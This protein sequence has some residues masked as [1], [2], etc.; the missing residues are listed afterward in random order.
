LQETKEVS[1]TV[2]I[3]TDSTCD[4]PQDV[5]HE[6]G[7]SVI[8]LY[9]NFG[10]RS[11]LDGVELSRR[12]FYEM[13]PGSDALPTTAVPGLPA[14]SKVYEDLADQ[15]A[16]AVVSIHIASTLSAT[17]DVARK[18]AEQTESIP[19]TVFDAGQVTVGTG[20]A[21]IAGANAASEGRSANDIVSLLKDL[22]PRIHSYAA[23][24]TVEFLRRSGRLTAIQYGLSTIL[25]IKPLIM[26][27]NG[28]LG[29]ERVRTGTGC[30]QRMI[31]L[32]TDLGPLEQLALVH[33]NAPQRA[34]ELYQQARHLFPSDETPLS[35]EVTP[36][37]GA[38]V[39]PNAVGLVAVAE[40]A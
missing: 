29:S 27:H 1:M 9:V 18:A 16:D 20:L 36:I 6:Y 32:V 7:I 17:C 8:P 3:V 5:L 4:L 14:F 19:V 30:I 34:Q 38:H 21:A 39:G 40:R 31:E 11:Y 22:A 12:E 35:V 15:G 10:S 26:M 13:L 24:D 33:T 2:K 28:E 37:I 23:L 25:G